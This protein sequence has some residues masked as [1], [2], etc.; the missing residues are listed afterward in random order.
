MSALTSSRA[1]DDICNYILPDDV[2]PLCEDRQPFKSIPR[3]TIR[4]ALELTLNFPEKR[5]IF[6]HAARDVLGINTEKLSDETITIEAHFDSVQLSNSFQQK[7]LRFGFEI[8]GFY[9]FN[10]THFAEHHTLKFKFDQTQIER[11]ARLLRFLKNASKQ[12]WDEVEHENRFE[13]YLEIE[14]YKSSDRVSWVPRNLKTDWENNLPLVHDAFEWVV[15]P[16]NL[17]QAT[18]RGVSLQ[19]VKRAD[20]HMKLSNTLSE[21]ERESFVAEVSKFG[22]YRV[23]TWSGNHVCTG[24]FSSGRKGRSVFCSFVDFFDRFGGCSEITFEPAL[25]L[26]RSNLGS[27]EAPE[28]SALPP[29]IVSSERD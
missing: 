5:G 21:I 10:P 12:L 1:I 14:K 23:I 7:L 29:L 4:S 3:T 13:A 9:K 18:S 11:G 25:M 16:T 17:Q 20:I 6:S 26:R 8:D 15:P 28:L 19:A 24:Q 22:F 2:I 27:S